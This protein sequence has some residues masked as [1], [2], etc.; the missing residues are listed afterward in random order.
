[1][2]EHR[3]APPLEAVFGSIQE[4]PEDEDCEVVRTAEPPRKKPCPPLVVNG[5][6]RHNRSVV[7][8]EQLSVMVASYHQ[9]FG[10][11]SNGRK[12]VLQLIPNAVWKLV[13][14]DFLQRFEDNL[15]QEETLKERLRDMLREL[16]TG[17]SNEEDSDRPAIQPEDVIDAIR[18]TDGRAAQNVLRVCQSMI[19]ARSLSLGSSESGPPTS[20]EFVSSEQAQIPPR[21]GGGAASQR[22]R[23]LGT[24]GR[25]APVATTGQQSPGGS[26]SRCV[27]ATTQEKEKM[28]SKA[29]ILAEQAKGIVTMATSYAHGEG[30]RESFMSA[31]SESSMAKVDSERRKAMFFTAKA[32]SVMFGDLLKL[33][34]AGVY[35]EEE[36]RAESKKIIQSFEHM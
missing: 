5:R 14:A 3:P 15:F 36:F 6:I 12:Q 34:D 23:T 26:N 10:K 33:R 27:S 13:Y 17:T 2:Q 20:P 8:S 9:H 25:A 32:K 28:L 16:K 7:E 19:D 31:R 30:H 21:A 11:Y 29:E 1:M 35:S 22:L 18:A 4:L 24:T